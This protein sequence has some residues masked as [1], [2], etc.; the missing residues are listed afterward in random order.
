MRRRRCSASPKLGAFNHSARSDGLGVARVVA[1]SVRKVRG[2]V[3]RKG[4]TGYDPSRVDTA[5]ELA[6]EKELV[7][8]GV[9]WGLVLLSCASWCRSQRAPREQC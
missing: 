1:V 2:K 4:Q 6:V 3:V 9:L 8:V 5:V 7:A